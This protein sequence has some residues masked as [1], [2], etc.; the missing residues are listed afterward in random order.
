MRFSC[1]SSVHA[2]ILAWWPV[3]NPG[4]Q[5]AHFKEQAV[6]VHLVLQ[7]GDGGGAQSAG[8]IGQLAEQLIQMVESVGECR[9]AGM[10]GILPAFAI[11]NKQA[12]RFV[13]QG[14][15]ERGV[16]GVGVLQLDQEGVRSGRDDRS[17]RHHDDA[18]RSGCGR[19]DGHNVRRLAMFPDAA[20]IE[21]GGGQK[22]ASGS[23]TQAEKQRPP[24]P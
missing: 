6:G 9:V 7:P 20:G 21:R 12:A 1:F 19:M 5:D 2:V 18:L 8:L 10:F 4:A 23:A 13:A 15:G 11:G 17:E 22:G 14:R 3:W 16:V 24:K